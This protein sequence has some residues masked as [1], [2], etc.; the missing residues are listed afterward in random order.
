[1]QGSIEVSLRS[2]GHE[3]ELVVRDSGT[4]IPAEDLPHIFERFYR[5]VNAGGRSYEGS[6]IGLAL[7]QE[8][9]KLNGGRIEVESEVGRGTTFTI[10]IPF[11]SA[12][13][14]KDRIGAT[15][16]TSS[17][18][19]SDAYLQEAFRWDATM[20]PASDVEFSRDGLR[21]GR[22]VVV[23][24]NR[25]MREY[26]SN[27]LSPSYE[28]TALADGNAALAEIRRHPPDL[29]LT[30]VMMPGLDGF[31]LLK[32]MRGGDRTA[33]I[34]LI[35]LSARA[36]EEARVEGASAGADDYLVKP[37]T[38]RELLARV[39]KNLVL[40]RL[41]RDSEQRVR[42]SEGRFRALA[43]ATF[44]SIYRM[45][46]DWS[47]MRPLS[48]DGFL[49][50]TSEP[51]RDWLRNY[52]LPEEQK[53]VWDAAQEAIRTRSM[54]VLE[55]RVRR[56]DGTIGWT[57]SRAI[58]V[59]DERG[60]ILEWFGAATD[61]TDRK[62]HQ[63]SDARLAA[64][65]DSADDAIISKDL[66]GVIRTWNHGAARMFGY[67]AEEAV[68]RSILMLIPKEL[69]HEE[70]DIL[71][72]LRAGE[73]I[74]HYETVRQTKSGEMLDVSITISPIRDE[75]GVVTGASKIARD[76]SDRR[77]IERLLLQS[78][79]LG[80]TGRMAA[81]IAHEI[82]NP[83]ESLINLIF[84]ARM[85]SQP[86][87]KTQKYLLTAEEELERVSHLARQTLGYY[88]DTSAPAEVQ[89]H[90]LL[91]NVLTVHNSRLTSAGIA[92]DLRF[93]DNE[94]IV[95]KKGELLQVF[96]NVIANAIDSMPEGGTLHIETRRVVTPR[97]EGLETIIR[98]SGV[99]IKS[100]D[101]SKVFEAFFTTK[102][103]RGTGIGLW[104]SKQ[105]IESRGG[106][107]SLASNA[108]QHQSGT[109]VTIFVPFAL[110]PSA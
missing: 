39:E 48:E 15:R 55:H 63:E 45:A 110:P 85:S 106:D 98:D 101:L 84:L 47:E 22:I 23:D 103:E 27:L 107:I 82:N 57:L 64:I 109:T 18:I 56:A 44:D 2:R 58:P 29:V 28:V 41:R 74:D 25:D 93:N 68:G 92:V 65:V 13:L 105:L 69:Q 95:A 102:G 66:N 88:R 5:V 54:F 34:P 6:G 100:Q 42:E 108:G 96:S 70:G 43:T 99:G 104:V 71:A 14:P 67:S 50:D 75:S 59:L 83:L 76:I 51:N 53:R 40:S 26:L 37:F 38:A 80:A 79:K 86:D 73:R 87:S 12:H 90:E 61:V 36:G 78:E 7:V 72:K 77:R 11:G 33:S 62:T 35:M 8:M 19:G 21:R 17:G 1:L 16:T 4:G 10:S 46:P 60:E 24:D 20:S 30:D 94:K 52:I 97:G 3:A 32:G 9:V 31:G 91:R 81:S 49:P 89:L